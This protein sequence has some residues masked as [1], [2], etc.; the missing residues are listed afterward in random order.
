MDDE[1][2]V[3][4]E[5]LDAFGVAVTFE[6]ESETSETLS[7]EEDCGGLKGPADVVSIAMDHTD[8]AVWRRSQWKP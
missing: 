7:G 1:I 3:W 4:Y 8:E 6:V 5:G 2:D